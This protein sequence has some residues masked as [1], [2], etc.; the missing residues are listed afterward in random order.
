[1]SKDRILI[2]GA[3]LAG[4]GCAYALSKAGKPS[5]VIEKD[6]VPGG[7]SKTI[8]F[9]GF[10][11]DIGGHRFISKSEEVNG[12]WQGFMGDDLLRVKRSSRIYYRGKYF[13]YPL[14]FINTLWNLGMLESFF[15]FLS[16]IKSKLFKLTDEDTFENWVINRFG[17]RLYKIF[18]K[19]YTEKVWAISCQNI[20]SDWAKQRMRGLSFR[21]AAREVF[22]GAKNNGPKSLAKE[23]LYPK[24]GP[25]E[26]I[27]RLKDSVAAMGGEFVFNK[28]LTSINHEGGKVLS[29]K[30]NDTLNNGIEEL[31]VD[32][33]FSS[34]PLPL[35]I[36]SLN[37][38]PPQEILDCARNLRFRSFLVV[39]II[40]DKKN[41]F[42]DQWIY[43][44]SA[45]VKI[46][47]VQN[48]K[49]WSSG[50]MADQTKTSL[51]IEYFCS[52]KD[53]LWKLDDEGLVS[54][55]VKELGKLGIDVENYLVDGFVV[56]Y[57]NAYPIYSLDYKLHL[58]KIRKYL[59]GFVN[60]QTMGRGGLFR[61][62]NSD[63]ALLTGFNAANN[64]LGLDTQDIWEI[65]CDKD[66]LES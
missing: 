55:A 8:N 51:G 40:L 5:L 22:W 62:D 16:Y 20:S 38:A 47:R 53:M 58:E 1:M 39:N 59:D 34:I 46:G 43:V 13:Q 63:H 33:L 37:P 36:E 65:D 41:I 19:A 17:E 29:I 56:R 35:F 4:I 66:Y 21:A 6:A 28:T 61:Y 3:G 27:R 64:Y 45:E 7:L 12:L 24:T 25:G 9:H 60:F 48:Y 15:C 2:A 44:H 50:M 54:F 14:S 30:I 49:N 23:F 32:Y 18:F 10:L 52:E 57:P 42:P 11:F 26:F 31:P